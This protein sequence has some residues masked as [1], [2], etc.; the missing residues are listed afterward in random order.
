MFDV[1]GILKNF[2]NLTRP[3]HDSIVKEKEH[4]ACTSTYTCELR[5]MA[6]QHTQQPSTCSLAVPG[7]A[8]SS[9]RAPRVSLNP[10]PKGQSG[11]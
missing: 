10:R 3:P 2:V 7:P 11:T 9:H 1:I 5:E 4:E 6:M 8:D